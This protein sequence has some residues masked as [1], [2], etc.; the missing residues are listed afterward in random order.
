MKKIN[1]EHVQALLAFINRSPYFQLLSM[2]VRELKPGYSRVEVALEEKKH[3]NAFGGLHGGVY[4]SV[5]DTTSFWAVY[6]EVPE[7]AGL[8]TID[9]NVNNLATTKEGFLIAEGQ[10]IKVGRSLCLAEATIRNAQGKILAHGS[11]KQMIT[12]GL[13]SINQ[14][15]IAKGLPPLPP[16]YL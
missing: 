2:E 14:A 10:Q 1:Q 16:K 7:D 3:L 12:Q 5:I 4:A 6:C 9:L 15:V 8:I 13:Q 11:S